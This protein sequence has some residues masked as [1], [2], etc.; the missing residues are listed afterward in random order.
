M[1]NVSTLTELNRA[2]IEIRLRNMWSKIS[3]EM[4]ALAEERSEEDIGR[5]ELIRWMDQVP[6]VLQDSSSKKLVSP[7]NKVAL[8]SEIESTEPKSADTPPGGYMQKTS[9][10]FV[11]HLFLSRYRSDLC[12]FEL[13]DR[14]LL[15][16]L[17]SSFMYRCTTTKCCRQGSTARGCKEGSAAA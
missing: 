13:L 3:E 16:L 5:E 11:A 2:A 7:T 17:I 1:R 4:A 15:N 14:Y 6:S 10:E 12:F 9:L 8:T